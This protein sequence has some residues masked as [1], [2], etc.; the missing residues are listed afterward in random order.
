MAE[1][2]LTMLPEVVSVQPKVMEPLV[3]KNYDEYLALVNQY[4]DERHVFEIVDDESKKQAKKIRAE[5]N[6]DIEKLKRGRIDGLKWLVGTFEDQIKGFETMLDT[7]QKAFG[8]AIKKFEDEQKAAE[9]AAA[10]LTGGP[11]NVSA[12]TFTLTI[13]TT[14]PKVVEKIKKIALDNNCTLSIK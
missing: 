5:I 7:R 13:K 8:A 2:E 11:V 4:L 9:A 10:G 14:D 3:I 6:A 1:K 12:K